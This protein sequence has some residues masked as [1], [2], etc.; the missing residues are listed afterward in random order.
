MQGFDLYAD[1]RPPETPETGVDRSGLVSARFA[2]AQ[3]RVALISAPAGY[4]KTT[5]LA[6]HFNNVDNKSAVRS[7]L[8]FDEELQTPADV[9]RHILA[10]I[11]VSLEDESLLQS[12]AF[13]SGASNREM[14]TAVL[15]FLEEINNDVYLYFDD[16]HTLTEPDSIGLIDALIKRLPQH[17]RLAI[18]SRRRPALSTAQFIANSWLQEIGA[19]DLRFSLD[20]TRRVIGESVK[21][22]SVDKIHAKTEGWATGVRLYALTE[23]ESDETLNAMQHAAHDRD[24]GDAYVWDY[25]TEQ[26]FD[27]LDESVKEFLM[28]TAILRRFDGNIAADVTGAEDAWEL[29]DDI[30]QRG[31][32]IFASDPRR[33]WYR[34]H[35]LFREFLLER[36]ERKYSKEETLSLRRKAARA[37][38]DQG[39]SSDALHQAFVIDDLPL[40]EDLATRFGGWRL[41]F[42]AGSTLWSRLE[43]YEAKALYPYPS[44]SLAVA[45]SFMTKGNIAEARR[46]YDEWKRHAALGAGPP[47]TSHSSILMRV[48]A[49]LVEL[50]IAWHEDKLHT[51]KAFDEFLREAEAIP[52]LDRRIML[53]IRELS[54]WLYFWHGDYSKSIVAAARAAQWCAEIDI[55]MVEFYAWVI[56]GASLGAIGRT[57]EALNACDAA[58]AVVMNNAGPDSAYT[59]IADAYKADFLL[60]QGKIEEANELIHEALRHVGAI[61]TYTD[62]VFTAYRTA[63][64][65]MLKKVGAQQALGLLDQALVSSAEFNLPVLTKL[66]A[67]HKARL[68]LAQP[69]ESGAAKIMRD[70]LEALT[71][72]AAIEEKR[73]WRIS[74][75]ALLL[76]ARIALEEQDAPEGKATLDAL[77]DLIK[78]LQAVRYEPELRLLQAKCAMLEGDEAAHKRYL[79]D[80]VTIAAPIDHRF[81]FLEEFSWLRPGL[82]ALAQE[83]ENLSARERNWLSDLLGSAHAAGAG[84]RPA[85]DGLSPREA[86]VFQFLCD[87]LTSKEIARELDISINTAMSYRKSLY[88]KLGASRRSQLVEIA[89]SL[90][91]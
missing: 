27:A 73:N 53:A 71:A 25:L 15:R 66:I 89:R 36:L 63:S 84:K 14:L 28:K 16:F 2:A 52:E 57:S 6:Q 48:D 62:F 30:Y 8:T 55:P 29:L 47:S 72:P 23:K 35:P 60:E 4:G 22:G 41:T 34:H 67:L 31:V 11:A 56:S 80:A 76:K 44:L 18:A 85:P 10:S 46:R 38:A 24:Q 54:A 42:L 58:R 21:S 26:V 39:R 13:L 32:F 37:L 1:I 59:A 79:L 77:E 75:Q 19:Q 43:P 81:V 87:G 91:A 7:W 12:G 82:I 61:D 9:A 45:H 88:R 74:V 68:S 51:L 5:L 70:D 64:W 83:D 78:E 33:E 49:P 3:T 17:V 50:L 20:E 90:S 65:C 86:Q 69:A 40:L